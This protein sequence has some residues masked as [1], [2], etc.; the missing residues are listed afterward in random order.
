MELKVTCQY[1]PE[2]LRHLQHLGEHYKNIKYIEN[3]FRHGFLLC[4]DENTKTDNHY[5]IVHNLPTTLDKL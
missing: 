1:D 2:C 4:H 3:I 5:K